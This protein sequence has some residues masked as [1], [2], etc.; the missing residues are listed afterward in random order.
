LCGEHE[1]QL[2]NYPRAAN[3]GVGLL[4]N[5]GKQPQFKRQVWTN[6]KSI[7]DNLGNPG[8]PRFIENNQK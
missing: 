1:A 4:L 7:L 2:L 3:I 5:F 8:D 6:Q